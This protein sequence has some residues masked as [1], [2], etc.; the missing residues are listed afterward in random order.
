MSKTTEKPALFSDNRSDL[1]RFNPKQ[2]YAG[3]ADASEIPGYAEAVRANDLAK[4]DPLWFREQNGKFDQE[5]FYRQVGAR[6][7]QLPVE[8]MWLRI[9]NPNGTHS[10]TAD[11]TLAH[12]TQREGFRP[13]H[14]S[15]F[16]SDGRF[17]E[18]GY[19]MPPTGRASEDGLIRRGPDTALYVRDGEVARMWEQHKNEKALEEASLGDT[20]EGAPAFE[21]R[22]KVAPE[23]KTI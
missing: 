7:A 18:L 13:V 3:D 21:S 23:F 10:A 19:S 17:T 4:A 2:W 15:E 22:E 12:Y 16:G 1:E 20:L 11:R 14:A 9:S 6:P 5:H 8:F